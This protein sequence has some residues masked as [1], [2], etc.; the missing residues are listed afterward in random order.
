MF[1]NIKHNY[2]G[3]TN[4]TCLS[5]IHKKNCKCWQIAVVQEE[6]NPSGT[7]PCVAL[8]FPLSNKEVFL[9]YSVLMASSDG[10]QAVMKL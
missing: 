2:N 10:R 9:F 5:L 6:W 7:R 3:Q 1:Q 4:I 8:L